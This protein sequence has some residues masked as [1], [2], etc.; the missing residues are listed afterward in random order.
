MNT[1]RIARLV[2]LLRAD[3][4]DTFCLYA[5]AQEYTKTGQLEEAVAQYLALLEVDADY[6]YGY[7]HLACTY[8]M[9]GRMDEALTV[10]ERG[11]ARAESLGNDQKAQSELADL[12]M[13]VRPS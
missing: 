7:Y 10:A 13:R 12:V 5:L 2:A 9:M 6:L 8:E 1:E 3:P 4:T 11:L